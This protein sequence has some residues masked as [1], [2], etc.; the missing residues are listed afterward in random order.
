MDEDGKREKRSKY[1]DKAEWVKGGLGMTYAEHRISTLYVG[2]RVPQG[3]ESSAA[4]PWTGDYGAPLITPTA[5]STLIGV[6][7]N[8]LPFHFE[9]FDEMKNPKES[10]WP[11]VHCH[12][13]LRKSPF[14]VCAILLLHL[15]CQNF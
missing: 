15:V 10:P 14:F 2:V 3:V 8:F 11:Q 7:S 1:Q 5:P 9:T 6:L 4:H 12:Y 13:D